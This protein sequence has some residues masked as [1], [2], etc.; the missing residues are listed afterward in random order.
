M[1]P[2]HI[3]IPQSGLD[4]LKGR[5]AATRWPDEMS[6]VGWKRGAPLAYLKELAEYW[7][8]TYDALTVQVVAELRNRST[9]G[10]TAL[11]CDGTRSANAT[12]RDRPDLGRPDP[13]IY[14]RVAAC[15]QTSACTVNGF[16]RKMGST[17]LKSAERRGCALPTCGCHHAA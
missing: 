2:F 6:D 14:G 9:F 13:H 16:P 12:R 15:T 17:S 7:R 5:I 8:T 4:D 3:E 11:R 10:S 1:H